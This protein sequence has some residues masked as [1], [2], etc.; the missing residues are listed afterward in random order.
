M[1]LSDKQRQA[2]EDS[3]MDLHFTAGK[4]VETS[5]DVHRK[6]LEV[7]VQEAMELLEVLKEEIRD[8][9]RLYDYKMHFFLPLQIYH[10]LKL[11]TEEK[12]ND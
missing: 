1:P 7:N 12:T 4:F 8:D 6:L 9:E 5:K 10:L 11:R 2:V 3:I